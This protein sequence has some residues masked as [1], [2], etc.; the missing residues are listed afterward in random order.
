MSAVSTIHGSTP[1]TRRDRMSS[2]KQRSGSSRCAQPAKL[3]QNIGVLALIHNLLSAKKKYCLIK[4][5]SCITCFS[6]LTDPVHRI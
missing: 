1:N 3:T 5:L 6:Y 2:V 4:N